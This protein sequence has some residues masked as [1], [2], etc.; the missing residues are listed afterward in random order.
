M[1]EFRSFL[2]I[3]MGTL[4]M[5]SLSDAS[6]GLAG[7]YNRGNALYRDGKFEAAIAAYEQVIGQG[8]ENGEVYYNLG[9][10]YYKNGQLGHAI[11]AYERALRLMPEDEDVR[12]NL[13][14]ANAH[15][16]DKEESEDPNF[17]TRVL[18]GVY[19]FW[20]INT[21]ALL[22]LIFVFGVGGSVVG[23]LFIPLR[24]T[25]WL[26]LFIFCL[27]GVIGN[28]VLLAFKVDQRNAPAAIILDA[29]VTGRSGP[30][31][32]FLQV[33]VL[34]EGTKVFVERVEEGWFLIRLGNGVGGWVAKSALE[35][36]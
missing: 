16:V 2:L 5:V 11:L 20:G 3:L 32:D 25:V 1:A 23:W 29:E 6:E 22:C 24:R 30:G 21:L 28:G 19:E 33:F 9:N 15:K 35:K 10:A 8:L 26:V 12:A 36:I 17:I 31:N 14:F 7:Q 18:Q 13:R 34:H 27:V 4:M